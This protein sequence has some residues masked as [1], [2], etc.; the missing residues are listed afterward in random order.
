[1]AIKLKDLQLS[2]YRFFLYQDFEGDEKKLVN[3]WNSFESV[4]KDAVERIGGFVNTAQGKIE[5]KF[6]KSGFF[7]PIISH[8]VDGDNGYVFHEN[9]YRT[10]DSGILHDVYSLQGWVGISEAFTDADKIKQETEK[11]EIEVNKSTKFEGEIPQE[12]KKIETEDNKPKKIEEEFPLNC[13]CFWS[14]IEKK[15]D[16]D[17]LG[18]KEIFTLLLKTENYKQIELDFAH[19]AFSV[20]FDERKAVA[21]ILV[22][23]YAPQEPKSKAVILLDILLHEYFLSLVKVDSESTIIS[24]LGT[25]ET[26]K[27]LIKNL[28]KYKTYQLKTLSEIE[29]TNRELNDLRADLGEKI[30]QSEAHLHTIDIN[31]DNAKEVLKNEFLVDKYDQFS[32]ILIAPMVSVSNQKKADLTYHKIYEEKGKVIAEE[33]ANLTNLQSSIYS[34]KLAWLFGLLALVGVLQL[35]EEFQSYTLWERIAILIAVVVLPMIALF[36]RD[37]WL[38]IKSLFRKIRRKLKATEIKQISTTNSKQLSSMSAEFEISQ[39][40]E[41]VKEKVKVETK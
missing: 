24:E 38:G 5:R 4:L 12:N 30:K 40:K 20:D 25:I 11:L 10:L 1:M 18:I 7:V 23:N 31:I 26:R 6:A 29:T 16:I 17:E 35:F 19:F 28:D 3:F 39:T 9:F 33:V 21:A 36:W 22:K 8:K 14:E 27:E 13:Y 32:E 34:R 2:R 15:R 37:I 41:M